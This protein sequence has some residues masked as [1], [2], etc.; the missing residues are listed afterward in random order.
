MLKKIILNRHLESAD[1]EEDET[2]VEPEQPIGA[3]T[4]DGSLNQQLTDDLQNLDNAGQVSEAT[5]SGRK[6]I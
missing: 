5:F 3:A 4:A 2:A 6:I 1:A